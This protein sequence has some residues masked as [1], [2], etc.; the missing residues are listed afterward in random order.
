MTIYRLKLI[1]LI[2]F[3][4]GGAA[5]LLSDYLGIRKTYAY[6][7][8]PPAGY[9]NALGERNCT[10]CHRGGNL[11]SGGTRFT[12]EAPT[13][14]Q[15]GGT[16]QI[17]VR[18]TTTDTSRK[19]WGFE[20]TTLDVNNARAGSLMKLSTTTQILD[21]AG[22]F[23]NR[24]YIE[25]T[26]ENG[27]DGTFRG[28]T[29]GASWTFNWTAPTTNVGPITF[30]ACG[31]Q[32]NNDG[33]DTGDQI[34]TTR[35]TVNPN[36][37]P[38]DGSQ[39]FVTQHYR[40]FLN[41][42]PDSSGLNFWVNQIASCNGDAQCIDIKRQNVSAA[43]FVSVEFQQTGYLVYRFTKAAFGRRPLY[44][45]FL[46]DTQSISRGVVVT[47]DNSNGYK[48]LLESNKQTFA[49]DFVN[50]TS[51]RG[52]HD[53]LNNMQYVD[54]LIANTGV[55][56]SQTDHDAL[57]NGLNSSPATETRATVMRKVAENQAFSDKEFNPAFV[58]MQY[59]GYLRRNPDDSPDNNLDGYNFWLTKLNTFNGDYIKAEM[60]R[61]FILSSEYRKRFGT[62]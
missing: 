23:G 33:G 32:A 49:N 4:I 26:T 34:Y 28:Q 45:R 43:Y 17:T 48:E 18:H 62:P 19:R 56:F 21:N 54:T 1:C 13:T 57:V 35:A 3:A 22:P 51:F 29:G 40:D 27:V 30:Y 10:E 55:T 11:L 59:F 24:Q 12:I 36:S 6:A 47:T 2:F 25:H 41:R 50:R 53:V 58:L 46:T 15:P 14:Y 52:I 44:D 16:Y 5:F 37:N 39:F 9:T 7:S 31:N 20:L 61:S 42:D 60:V 8:G 38:I